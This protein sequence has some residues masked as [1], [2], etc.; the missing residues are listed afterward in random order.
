MSITLEKQTEDFQIS[1]LRRKAEQG[2]AK[3]QFNLGMLYY[4]GHGVTQDYATA[5][6]WWEQAA[7]QG[8][9][10]AQYNLGVLYKKG[11][12]APQDDATAREWF[13]KSAVQA[14]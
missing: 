3:T 5:R 11:R 1:D 12:G 9:A 4:E 2:D 14:G 6:H 8:N 13:E 7:A 10:A